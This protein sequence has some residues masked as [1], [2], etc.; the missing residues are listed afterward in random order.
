VEA[1][2]ITV[3]VTP[4]GLTGTTSTTT[5]AIGP[6]G[7]APGLNFIQP[8]EPPIDD[9]TNTDTFGWPLG[10]AAIILLVLFTSVLLRARRARPP[11]P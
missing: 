3:T 5:P 6:T 10:F 9:S 1:P 2:T 7:T 8:A 4:I 11:R